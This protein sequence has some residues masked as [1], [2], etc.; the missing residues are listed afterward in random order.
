MQPGAG[1]ST[2][3][4]RL[5][6]DI[7]QP[8]WPEILALHTN[9][10]LSR[11]CLQSSMTVAVEID[12]SLPHVSPRPERVVAEHELLSID[13]QFRIR[14]NAPPTGAAG[15]HCVVVVADDKMLPA[16]QRRQQMGHTL[17]RLAHSEVPQV[18]NLILRTDHRIPPIYHSLV[19][20]GDRR[21]W[22]TIEGPCRGM[23]EVVIA[24]KVD[25]HWFTSQTAFW[26]DILCRPAPSGWQPR[27]T[28]AS[29]LVVAEGGLFRLSS[30]VRVPVIYDPATE[31]LCSDGE[32]A[33]IRGEGSSLTSGTIR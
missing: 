13:L 22:P 21:E 5:P 6:E 19:H 12:R 26:T 29:T 24:G 1:S 31:Y 11:Q 32:P 25:G 28:A 7:G 10:E 17:C 27:F 15:H 9:I 18:P 4:L 14:L 16:M 2:N 33:A 3:G 20:L 30:R 23:A 8:N